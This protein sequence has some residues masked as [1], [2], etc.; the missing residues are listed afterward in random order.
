M[1]TSPSSQLLKLFNVVISCHKKGTVVHIGLYV[2]I[3]QSLWRVASAT[4]D[5]R[6]PS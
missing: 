6:L 1:H 3:P 2:D 4:P 5:R